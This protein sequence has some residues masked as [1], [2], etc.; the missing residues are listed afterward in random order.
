MAS[1]DILL[2]STPSTVAS[3]KS[4]S[5]RLPIS[6]QHFYVL[7]SEKGGGRATWWP[8]FH[9][10]LGGNPRLLPG[11]WAALTSTLCMPRRVQ[12]QVVE[13]PDHVVSRLQLPSAPFCKI[14]WRGNCL[15][16]LLPLSHWS[17]PRGLSQSHP[18]HS[19]SCQ[20]RMR[21]FQGCSAGKMT[22]LFSNRLWQEKGTFQ[23]LPA[24]LH[25]VLSVS[26]STPWRQCYQRTLNVE[27]TWKSTTF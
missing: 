6:G 26:I 27:G 15:P 21:T 1:T 3:A 10:S 23:T 4:L 13:I 22:P 9:L 17:L 2:N 19:P 16:Q 5:G 8:S 20:R 25:L 18:R 14:P 24:R 11:A 12:V 7:R